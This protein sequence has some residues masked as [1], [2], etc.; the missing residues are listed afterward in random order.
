[1]IVFSGCSTAYYKTYQDEGYIIDKRKLLA[2]YYKN[3]TE[4]R[5]FVKEL[6]RLLVKNGFAVSDENN[7]V[8]DLLFNLEE[9]T[10]EFTGSYT[11]YNTSTITTNT[12]GSIGRKSFSGSS[13]STITTPQ[14]NYYT[15]NVN[16]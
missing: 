16:L 2:V 6:G 11:T 9:P 10:Y 4:S 8:C 12:S 5:K 7:A 14:T 13:T 1:M 3:D 15:Y